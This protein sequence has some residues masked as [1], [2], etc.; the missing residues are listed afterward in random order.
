MVAATK[1]ERWVAGEDLL[2]E[3]SFMD[4]RVLPSSSFLT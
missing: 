2:L 3:R 1:R 4:Q